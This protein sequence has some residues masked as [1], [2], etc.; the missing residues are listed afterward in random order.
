M[1]QSL[2]AVYLSSSGVVF[3]VMIVRNG[4]EFPIATCAP[5]KVAGAALAK[6]QLQ[7]HIHPA[8]RMTE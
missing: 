8:P 7:G 2:F 5:R 1:L 4:G 3:V 6:H